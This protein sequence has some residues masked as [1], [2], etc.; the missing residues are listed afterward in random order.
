MLRGNW[1]YLP[2]IGLVAFALIAFGAARSLVNRADRLETIYENQANAEARAYVSRAN[3]AIERRCRTL[4]P[5]NQFQ[6]VREERQTARQGTHN[7]RDVEAQAISTIW[8]KYTDIAVIFGTAA[9]AIGLL[10]ILATFV[11]NKRS[12][13]AAADQVEIMR[14]G[15]RPDIFLRQADYYGPDPMG[16]HDLLRERAT[17]HV[18]FKNQGNGPA[19][20]RAAAYGWSVTNDLPAVPEYP[21]QMDIR[22]GVTLVERDHTSGW[23]GPIVLTPDDI[24]S[25]TAGTADLWVWLKAEFTDREDGLYEIAD[26][27]RWGRGEAR[28]ETGSPIAFA[29][30]YTRQAY[31]YRKHTLPEDL[32]RK[33]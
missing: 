7:V 9:G 27:L 12:A 6:C 29:A 5:A 32:E 4:A 25:V 18:S 11:Q 20:P 21:H 3:V 24:A 16:R 17:F 1:R 23:T 8:T 13:D 22:V 33:S 31:S 30:V 28:N 26:L 15:H 10:L 2:A 19:Y 14:K